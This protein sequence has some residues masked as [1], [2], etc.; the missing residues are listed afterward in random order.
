MIHGP[1]GRTE[2]RELALAAELTGLEE[3]A[4]LSLDGELH[5]P[6]GP[7]GRLS[8]GGAVQLASGGELDP[9]TVSGRLELELEALS[10]PALRPLAAS[11]VPV[12]A[13]EGTAA[14]S[15][16]VQLARGGQLSA[17]L[18][19]EGSGLGAD[20]PWAGERPLRPGDLSLRAELGGALEDDLDLSAELRS[21]AG[22]EATLT[23]SLRDRSALEA[24]L[25][26]AG[27]SAELVE[28]GRGWMP[29]REGHALG[30]DFRAEA[31]LAAELAEGAPRRA[32]LRLNG[33][34]QG[35]AVYGPG[36]DPLAA[37]D[38]WSLELDGELAAAE[39]RLELRRLAVATGLVDLAASGR[40]TGWELTAGVLDLTGLAIEEGTYALA[41]DLDRVNALLADAFDLGETRLGGALESDGTVSGTAGRPRVTAE[42][43]VR[44]LRATGAA[45]AA[46]DAEPWSAGP[47]D[48]RGELRADLDLGPGGRSDL[49][50][51]ALTSEHFELVAAGALRDLADP[52]RVA[53]ELVVEL[54]GEP[55]AAQLL[56]APWRAGWSAAGT[57]VLADAELR[58][59]GL[60]D[61]R[62]GGELR[63]GRLVLERAGAGGSGP[64]RVELD[65]LV[66]TA[67]P[68][69]G[70]GL[71]L[72]LAGERLRLE[73]PPEEGSEEARSLVQAP[74][75]LS[76]ALPRDGGP[77]SAELR[78]PAGVL[79]L[80]GALPR[81]GAGTSELDVRFT[82]DAPLAPLVADLGPLLGG[83]RPPAPADGELH[84]EGRL[85]ADAGD[86]VLTST[87]RITDLDWTLPS[88]DPEDRAPPLRLREPEVTLDLGGRLSEGGTRLSIERA[89]LS[90]ATLRADVTGRALL[91][92]AAETAVV[93][94]LRGEL[95]Y[96]PDRLAA[97]LGPRLPG[98]LSGSEEEHGRFE[99][100][101][102]LTELDLESLLA[103]TSLDGTF[104]LG[105]FE[106]AGFDTAGTVT[107]ET[108]DG[109]ARSRGELSAGGGVLSFDAV[110]DLRGPEAAGGAPASSLSVQ[111]DAVRTRGDTNPLLAAIHPVFAAA[112]SRAGEAPLTALLAGSLELRSDGPLEWSALT[113]E[114]PFPL[115]SLSGSARLEVLEAAVGP[116][117][118]LGQL[119]AAL[120]V[121]EASGF[122]VRPIELSLERGRIRYTR[123]WTW[124]LGGVET[125]FTGTVGLDRSLALSWDVPV[126]PGL[127]ERERI[128]KYLEGE[129]IQ[130][131][132]RGTLERPRIELEPLL[133]QLVSRAAQKQLREALLGGGGGGGDPRE[134]DP[135]AILREADELWEA[136]KKKK[137][138]KLYEELRDEH[139]HTLVYLLN[140]DRIKDRQPKN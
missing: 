70:A 44:G 20:G 95:R 87:A 24:T 126:T 64:R 136:G 46:T 9:G 90:S 84:A 22:L 11:L 88:G 118:F 39:R 128:L 93:E 103:S 12:S 132:I 52:A 65:G 94:E 10:L 81:G 49:E 18:E 6:G 8:G 72:A 137:A 1:G 23:G 16:S 30:G 96:V 61:L 120:G 54:R 71:G 47:L 63:A 89:L 43:A 138:R 109:R 34:L 36:G 66:A 108:A 99:W 102:P 139:R 112:S 85:L 79:T 105:R 78:S 62:L 37:P 75:E 7:G 101:G 114:A 2:L 83:A 58:L 116:G 117:S 35:F 115:E 17:R 119:L 27:G 125:R 98:R 111:L 104:D 69:P 68:G 60:E 133:P 110:L 25:V 73:L 21:G 55:A 140:R 97:V 31:H 5:G 127:V 67:E 19:L 13:L 42:L 106:V 57:E 80:T 26:T 15:A 50:R 124:T 121:E 86:W 123:P 77:A 76:A 107:V 29:L 91:P 3:P 59:R 38:D 33:A 131:P 56:P 122:D 48:L 28:L 51:L 130:I 53:G 4:S 41:A 113:G 32:E 129:L 14:G 92:G 100:S 45:T 135:A 82:A 40:L 74:F 134:G